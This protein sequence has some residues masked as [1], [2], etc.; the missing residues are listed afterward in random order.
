MGPEK[1]TLYKANRCAKLHLVALRLLVI[2]RESY[3]TLQLVKRQAQLARR[4]PAA[5]E[6]IERPPL[7]DDGGVEEVQRIR[8]ETE[9]DLEEFI[10]REDG[11]ESAAQRARCRGWALSVSRPV[12]RASEGGIPGV[13]TEW[14]GLRSLAPLTQRAYWPSWG[15][16]SPRRSSASPPRCAA[17]P[18]S[19][20]R[21]QPHG[22]AVHG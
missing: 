8:G 10:G 2:L 7:R 22:R 14:R 18:R 12:E 19:R 17:P 13:A 21:L 1:R 9:A 3:H 6:R 20:C 5:G 11:R 15:P 4:Q 16:R